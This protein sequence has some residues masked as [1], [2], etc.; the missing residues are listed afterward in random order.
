MDWPVDLGSRSQV[1]YSET[2]RPIHF[3]G[4]VGTNGRVL[5]DIQQHQG[6]DDRFNL[7]ER[8]LYLAEGNFPKHG[9]S[10]ISQRS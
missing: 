8:V 4:L 10:N 1:Q 6:P 5:G 7:V 3:A 9:S 2:G